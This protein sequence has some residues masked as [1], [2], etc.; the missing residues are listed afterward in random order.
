MA[1]PTDGYVATSSL[2]VRPI[3]RKAHKLAACGYDLGYDLR[4]KETSFIT[5]FEF[6]RR[7]GGLAVILHDL[8]V[9]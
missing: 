6:L 5:Q 2:L 4:P 9:L 1:T 7:P 3:N 8:H